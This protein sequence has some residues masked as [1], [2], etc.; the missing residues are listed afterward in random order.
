MTDQE[1]LQAAH[2]KLMDAFGEFDSLLR[3]LDRNLWERWKAGGK[4]V[5]NDYASMYPSATECVEKFVP[6]DEFDEEEDEFDEEEDYQDEDPDYTDVC[7]QLEMTGE[8][9]YLG[10]TIR[11]AAQG[12]TITGHD[13]YPSVASAMD[14]VEEMDDRRVEREIDE[15]RG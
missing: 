2:D 9:N 10:Y 12:Y 7:N 15:S 1:A 4:D 13:I 14:A 5:S 6:T 11:P 8:A 3:Q